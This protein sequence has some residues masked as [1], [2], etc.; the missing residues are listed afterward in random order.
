MKRLMTC[1]T[2]IAAIIALT[3]CEKA[4]EVQIQSGEFNVE[5]LFTVDGCTA[6]RFRDSGKA[7]Y[8]TN[9]HGSTQ[10]EYK[11]GKVTK[12]EIVQTNRT[13]W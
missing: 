5:R 12:Q 11:S 2:I 4:P 9:C 13:N 10:S 6:Y 1:M 8:Y 3:G 7:V